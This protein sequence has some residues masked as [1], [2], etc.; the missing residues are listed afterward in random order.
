[1]QCPLQ[2][3]A[4]ALTLSLM[5]DGRSAYRK[6]G[7]DEFKGADM[8][9]VVSRDAGDQLRSAV[10]GEVYTPDD[11]G[12]DQVRQDPQ[13]DDRQTAGGDRALPEHR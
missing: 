9:G 13:R 11:V 12:Y 7:R 8:T 1:M 3:A 4:D 2:S 10:A 6:V 5:A